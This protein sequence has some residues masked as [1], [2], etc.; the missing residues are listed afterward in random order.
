MQTRGISML[1]IINFEKNNTMSQLNDASHKAL[2]D[3]MGLA[4]YES[5][6]IVTDGTKDEIAH[7]LLLAGREL[8]KEAFLVEIKPG[9]INGQEPPEQIAQLM[10]MVDVVICPTEKSLTHTRARLDAAAAGVRVATMPGI[11]VE[12]MVRC[13]NADYQKVISLTRFI[14]EK[15]LKTSVIRVVTAKALTS[16][17]P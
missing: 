16:V 12:T 13:L 4:A 14:A 17:C 1:R 5:L 15:L 2:K 11:S 6:L 8:C 10:K 9:E 7:S 3:Y